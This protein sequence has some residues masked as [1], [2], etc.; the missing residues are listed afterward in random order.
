M[1]AAPP[2]LAALRRLAMCSAAATAPL[3]CCAAWLN[4]LRTL[5][6]RPSPRL[7][8][9][10]SPGALGQPGPAMPFGFHFSDLIKGD[11]KVPEAKADH[12]IPPL[13]KQLDALKDDFALAAMLSKMNALVTE[14]PALIDPTPE[15]QTA[16]DLEAAVRKCNRVLLSEEGALKTVSDFLAH[17]NSKLVRYACNFLAG[18]CFGDEENAA[19]VKQGLVLKELVNLFDSK[20]DDGQVAAA[21]NAALAA[22]GVDGADQKKLFGLIKR[23]E[24]EVDH[25]LW[26]AAVRTF[27]KALELQPDNWMA[28]VGRCKCLIEEEEWEQ[29]DLDATMLADTII[30]D[31]GQ[32]HGLAAR[33]RL[34]LKD[35][36]GAATRIET[37]EELDPEHPDVEGVRF[38]YTAIAESQ[39]LIDSIA[40]AR[41]ASIDTIKKAAAFAPKN[42]ELADVLYATDTRAATLL[43]DTVKTE[44]LGRTIFD[45]VQAV[46]AELLTAK[47]NFQFGTLA[48]PIGDQITDMFVKLDDYDDICLKLAAAD[49]KHQPAISNERN[50]MAKE[51]AGPLQEL[52]EAYR[53]TVA[54]IQARK[55]DLNQRIATLETV[56]A[57]AFP[58]MSIRREQ[59]TLQMRESAIIHGAQRSLEEALKA[60]L[61][62]FASPETF[63]GNGTVMGKSLIDALRELEQAST[64]HVT[65]YQALMQ[66]K[67]LKEQVAET[68]KVTRTRFDLEKA[69]EKLLGDA[70]DEAQSFL[71]AVVQYLHW[72]LD[73]AQACNCAAFDVA[74]CMRERAAHMN[75]LG[76]SKAIGAKVK[77][78]LDIAKKAKVKCNVLLRRATANL[79]EQQELKEIGED[80]SPAEIR[81]LKEKQAAAK[82]EVS[83]KETEIAELTAKMEALA[84]NGMPELSQNSSRR[85]DSKGIKHLRVARSLERDYQNLAPQAGIHPVYKATYNGKGVVL[86]GYKGK[87]DKAAFAKQLVTITRLSHPTIIHV[88]ALFYD[89]KEE[90]TFAQM[91]LCTKGNFRQWSLA[92]QRTNDELHGVLKQ[93]AQGLAYLHERNIIHGDIKPEALLMY[94]DTE[95]RIG[96]FELHAGASKDSS[97]PSPP[98][99]D[100]PPPPPAFDGPPADGPPAAPAFDGDEVP[101]APAADPADDEV[102]EFYANEYQGGDSEGTAGYAAPELSQQ[103]MMKPTT[104]A[105]IWSFGAVVFEAFYK[106][107]PNPMALVIPP[108]TLQKN[109]SRML[110]MVLSPDPTERPSAMN[111]VVCPYFV[112]PPW[113]GAFDVAF[114]AAERRQHALY[115]F[116]HSL[117]TCPGWGTPVVLQVCRA[118]ICGYILENYRADWITRKLVV[119]FEHQFDDATLEILGRPSQPRVGSH[120]AELYRLFFAQVLD[121][122]G[123][124]QIDKRSGVVSVNRTLEHF[125]KGFVEPAIR[126]AQLEAVGGMMAKCLLDG[127]ACPVKF[128]PAVYKYLLNQSDTI[129]FRDLMTVEPEQARE[130]TVLYGVPNFGVARQ[131]NFD[132]VMKWEYEEMKPGQ[133]VPVDDGAKHA[134]VMARCQTELVQKRIEGLSAMYTGFSLITEMVLKYM[135]PQAAITADDL[136][137]VL[138]ASPLV[139]ARDVN[140]RLRFSGFSASATLPTLLPQIIT[141]MSS[142]QRSTFVLFLTGSPCIPAGGICNPNP[143][144]PFPDK[145]TIMCSSYDERA[146]PTA[147]VQFYAL[148]TAD[149]ADK[150]EFLTHLEEGLL[151]HEQS[152]PTDPKDVAGVVDEAT[153]EM[154][155]G[156][157]LGFMME[158]IVDSQE[159]PPVDPALPPPPAA[160]EQEVSANR[161]TAVYDYASDQPGDLQFYEGSIL[162]ITAN[163]GAWWQGYLEDDPTMTTGKFPS[164]YVEPIEAHADDAGDADAGDA[165]PEAGTAVT[166][167]VVPGYEETATALYDFPPGQPGDL[168]FNAG[169]T[170]VVTEKT[171]GGWWQGYIMGSP[172]TTGAF[173]SNYASTASD[174][175]GAAG[176]GGEATLAQCVYDYVAQQE[177]DLSIQVGD[178]V[179]V[180]DQSGGEW[181]SGYVESDP[182]TIGNFPSNCAY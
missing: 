167:P 59:L 52:S 19:V 72:Y 14:P 22:V 51:L 88:D 71:F 138:Q 152:E 24:K 48:D 60:Y 69:L 17:K 10:R 90:I 129:D 16:A 125:E 155:S 146:L 119:Y 132:K 13:V 115:S 161:A 122:P 176:G 81:A 141:D 29:A 18:M 23:A 6:E 135:V 44:E 101:P 178:S 170:I 133:S 4:C 2:P 118:N 97:P 56:V 93:A 123:L 45:A 124:W 173:P 86:K 134:Y 36:E 106:T 30:P 147:H 153:L 74:L 63:D 131:Y 103:R 130:L 9:P 41:D 121:V 80:V 65:T 78:D 38:L 83:K 76:D 32:A 70:A 160:L 113:Q 66:G 26:S 92:K 110:E 40:A 39:E 73:S 107:K 31:S 47:T 46:R 148:E 91:E 55:T 136:S 8:L 109:L 163:T 120:L 158:H 154:Q 68:Q 108:E 171:E 25:Q 111:I 95:L 175:S 126:G 165:E 21:A 33:T 82:V 105:D 150:K 64:T 42:T 174:S 180:V 5:G 89:P 143:D 37:A 117:R 168:S 162:V 50:E 79:E 114:S 67:L 7:Q 85:A 112:T 169:D 27:S 139:S 116:L 104:A 102:D 43:V 127:F 159:Q 100:G 177:G 20:E 157:T 54:K 3:D 35:F 87:S 75:L 99:F 96:D 98:A 149:Y 28:M 145:L 172:G 182:N 15:Q 11:E 128:A 140:D 62:F 179:I 49:A 77:V 156:R 151:E 94:S 84:S 144:W 34:E 164:N 1:Q 53:P 57:A 137:T 181:W 61:P 58:G 142:A 166:V 12:R